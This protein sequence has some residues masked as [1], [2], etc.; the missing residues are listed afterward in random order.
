MSCEV[1]LGASNC[2][3]C[4]EPTWTEDELEAKDDFEIEEIEAEIINKQNNETTNRN[5]N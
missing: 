3:V 5:S 4:E 2:P 1:C